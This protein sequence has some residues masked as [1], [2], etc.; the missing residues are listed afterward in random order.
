MEVD[1]QLIEG[2]TRIQQKGRPI[3]IHLK[4]AVEN[5]IE[6]L[7]KQGHIQKAKTIDENCCVSPAVITIKK[8]KSVKRALDSRK[9]N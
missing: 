4:T 2:S 8:D 7:K 5:E 3:P 1:I 6:K 9:L